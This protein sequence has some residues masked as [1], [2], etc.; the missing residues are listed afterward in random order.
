MKNEFENDTATFP[1]DQWDL[2][3]SVFKGA[4]FLHL[5]E[6]VGDFAHDNFETILNVS[7]DLIYDRFMLVC[8]MA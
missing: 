8:T 5:H 7:R 6:D 2:I 1:R 3:D 4:V